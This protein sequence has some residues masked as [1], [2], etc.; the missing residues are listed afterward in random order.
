MASRVLEATKQRRIQRAR[1]LESQKAKGRRREVGVVQGVCENA[2]R[3]PAADE[4][5]DYRS[6]GPVPPEPDG[7]E[8]GEEVVRGRSMR[9]AT[10]QK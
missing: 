6:T 4:N 1:A 7:L 5:R 10:F 8:V 9:G 3:E 2:T